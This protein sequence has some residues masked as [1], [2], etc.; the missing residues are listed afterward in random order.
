MMEK[1]S[2]LRGPGLGNGFNGYGIVDL[3]KSLARG[4]RLGFLNDLGNSP[5]LTVA[6]LKR[7]DAGQQFIQQQPERVK[8]GGGGYGLA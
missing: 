5:V 7:M 6:K 2:R 3:F 4:G 1:L 8:V